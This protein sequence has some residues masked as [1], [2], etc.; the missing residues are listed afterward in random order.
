MPILVAL[1]LASYATAEVVSIN[2]ED[3]AVPAGTCQ[4]AVSYLNTR[5]ISFAS[6]SANVFG[7][8]VCNDSPNVFSTV[9]S[10]GIHFFYPDVAI[11][12]GTYQYELIFNRPEPLFEFSFVR[13]ATTSGVPSWTGQAIDPSGNVVQT[14]SEVFPN[15]G[16]PA[17]I[18]FQSAQIR[19]IRIRTDSPS[20]GAVTPAFDDFSLTYV[21]EPSTGSLA[22]VAGLGFLIAAVRK[23]KRNLLL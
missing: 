1:S 11:T 6:L 21:P 2:F 5:G 9:P 8:T 10:S 7:P 19:R 22:A 18:L 14:I 20:A 12:G 16:L 15:S 3:A 23:R 17:T 4:G 13:L